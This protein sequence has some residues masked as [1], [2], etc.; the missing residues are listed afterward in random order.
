VQR[1]EVLVFRPKFIDQIEQRPN[2]RH[3]LA[4]PKITIC[5]LN[6]PLVL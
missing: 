1:N 2:H 6:Y 5:A 4:G 3:D